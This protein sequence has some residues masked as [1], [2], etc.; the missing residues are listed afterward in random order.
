MFCSPNL[1]S[2]GLK[3]YGLLLLN[4]CR[5]ERQET[6][7]VGDNSFKMYSGAW[8]T[9]TACIGFALQLKAKVTPT[10]HELCDY[11]VDVEKDS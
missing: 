6:R 10:K 8:P 5:D 4:N 2:Y 9:G 11:V 3:N 7:E 1:V